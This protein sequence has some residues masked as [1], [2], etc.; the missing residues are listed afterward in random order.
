[1]KEFFKSAFSKNGEVSSKRVVGIP[2][3]LLIAVTFVILTLS[4]GEISEQVMSI[5]KFTLPAVFT[6]LVSGIADGV[7]K[8]KK[9]DE[10][11]TT[12]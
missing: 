7:V 12:K 1:M 8:G 11:N 10:T 6:L 5:Y 4:K 3:G 2:F 9:K